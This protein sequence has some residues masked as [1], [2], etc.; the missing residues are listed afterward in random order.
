MPNIT[1]S[2]EE[3][4]R[5]GEEIYFSRLQSELEPNDNGKYVVIEVNS[6]DYIVD[7]DVLGAVN[8]AQQKYP[9]TLFYIAA[10]G[11]VTKPQADNYHYAWQLSK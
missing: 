4:T 2:P 11:S 8:Q 7:R 3:L 1:D 6:G 9:N 5:K 10:I